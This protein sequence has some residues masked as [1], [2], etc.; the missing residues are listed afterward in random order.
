MRSQSG[1]RTAGHS[2]P[3]RPGL[4]AIRPSVAVSVTSVRLIQAWPL[5][6][7][8]YEHEGADQEAGRDD[9]ADLHGPDRSVGQELEEQ[10]A[11]DR[12]SDRAAELLHSVQ[13]TGGSDQDWSEESVVARIDEYFRALPEDRFPLVKAMAPFLT[14]GDGQVRFEFGL[15]VLVAGLDSLKHW[16]PDQRDSS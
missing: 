9:R 7:Q 15:S 3:A 12:H 8:P 4:A 11:G 2:L 13:Q 1:L 5:R 14:A 10:R 6:Q 16:T